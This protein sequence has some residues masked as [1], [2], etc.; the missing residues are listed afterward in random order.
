MLKV[1]N[2]N[3]E[4]LKIECSSEFLKLNK[5]Y[6]INYPLD[7]EIE[8]LKGK[9]FVKIWQIKTGL[10]DNENS[11]WFIE[12]LVLYIGFPSDFPNKIPK[13][14][15]HKNNIKSI[16][17]IPHLT[18]KTFDICLYDNYVI[19]DKNNPEGIITEII[20]KAIETLITG[21]KKEN[22]EEFENEFSA[23]WTAENKVA[24]TRLFYSII[25]NFP[26]DINYL[27]ALIYFKGKVK[28]YII[29][30]TQEDKV[31][32][33]KKY[34][35]NNQVAY[36]D[37]ELFFLKEIPE[38]KLPSYEYTYEESL[39]LIPEEKQTEFKNYFNK[40]N[41]EKIV[42]F[43]KKIKNKEI[44]SGWLYKDFDKKN[45]K[46]FRLE[47]LND[48]FVTFTK[49]LPGHKEIIRKF[50]I[51]DI[52]EKRLTE[53]TATEHQ[54]IPKYNL[55]IA[56]LG[57]VGSHV[58]SRLN[59]LNFPN[60][61]LIDDDILGTENIGRHF[62]GFDD[63]NSYKTDCVGMF[64]L[65][66]NPAQKVEVHRSSFIDVYNKNANVFNEQD[67]IFLCTGEKNLELDLFRELE[68]GNIKKPIF[69]I[70][71]EPF[72]VGGH[73]VY[74]CPEDTFNIDDLYTDGYK[75]KHSVIKDSEYDD[76]RDL[77]VQKE[78]GC[79]SAF[80]PYS[81]SHLELFISSIYPEIFKI[82]QN[83]SNKSLI[84]CWTG[85]LD[86][87]KKMNIEIN[88][89]LQSFEVKIQRNDL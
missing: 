74:M 23:Y 89:N 9:N 26:N 32:N 33:Y 36:Q 87:A 31:L 59:S 66:K 7:S 38:I 4:A 68:K 13:V 37:V 16:G 20:D 15:L 81:A 50:N 60:F 78:I 34:L 61:T 76:K 30:N 45:I 51:N 64:L 83:D 29:Y 88:N 12:D 69:R 10:Y 39:E 2:V 56:G 84:V 41:S 82:I 54:I 55:L 77:F 24:L 27:N 6:K 1:H 63:V 79:Q 57:S 19:T 40:K 62:L 80:S 44:L 8:F 73:L 67:Y 72:L 71:L 46:G 52:N 17:T 65:N 22:L 21:I 25:N 28:K 35:E 14:F 42:L 18:K 58:T 48:F 5:D 53:R 70:W 75:F 49:S 11:K 47:M 3:F 86:F 85:D 43:L